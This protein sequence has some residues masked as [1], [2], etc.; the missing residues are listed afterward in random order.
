MVLLIYIP[1]LSTIGIAV[2]T[3]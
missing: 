1:G 2:Q 3:I